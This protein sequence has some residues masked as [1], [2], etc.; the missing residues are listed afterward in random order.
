MIVTGAPALSIR[1]QTIK[2]THRPFRL[3]SRHLIPL[4]GST[5]F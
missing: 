3:K 1:R 4:T 5:A 2:R